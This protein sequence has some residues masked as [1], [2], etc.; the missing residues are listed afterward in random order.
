MP[1]PPATT[2]CSIDGLTECS[3]VTSLS[4][5]KKNNSIMVKLTTVK[6]FIQM[7]FLFWKMSLRFRRVY[8]EQV[9]LKYFSYLYK[10]I[11]YSLISYTYTKYSLIFFWIITLNIIYLYC[12]VF[13]EFFFLV[14]ID[15]NFKCR[16]TVN[17]V[18]HVLSIKRY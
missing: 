18:I 5:L 9:L 11:F 4:E 1:F 14:D 3:K 8:T 10:F 17:N 2:L 12:I 16:T 6:L 13:V 15:F 7:T